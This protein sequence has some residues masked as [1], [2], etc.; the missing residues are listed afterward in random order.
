MYLSVWDLHL[1]FC[2][3]GSFKGGN[4]RVPHP[5]ERYNVC[6]RGGGRIPHRSERYN[7][8]R[9]RWCDTRTVTRMRLPLLRDDQNLRNN[10]VT[11]G[12]FGLATSA[13]SP[14]KTVLRP[15]CVRSFLL[16]ARLVCFRF[17]CALLR[18]SS[19]FAQIIVQFLAKK[20]G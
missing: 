10:C 12:G 9:Q 17:W 19:F 8:C 16:V 20:T 1:P 11:G 14:L 13:W 2:I 7:V 6:R 3:G 4:G 15:Q 18:V 5:S